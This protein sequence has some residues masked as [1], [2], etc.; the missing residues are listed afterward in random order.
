MTA[1]C[2]SDFSSKNWLTGQISYNYYNS[3]YYMMVHQ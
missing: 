3:Y 1:T 2:G